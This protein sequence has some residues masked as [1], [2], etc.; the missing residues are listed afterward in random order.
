MAISTQ[1]LLEALK[2]LSPDQLSGIL[3]Q[4]SNRS[5]IR[6]R[7]LHDLRLLPT[8]KDPRPMWVQATDGREFGPEKHSPFPALLW[9][10][11]TGEEITVQSEA[12]KQARGAMWT[13]TPPNTKPLDPEA[14]AR[15]MFEALSPEDQQF[16]IEMQRKARMDA[17]SAAM[18]ALTP[19]QQAAALGQPVE[20]PKKKKA[21]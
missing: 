1:D 17:V 18:S 8:A 21:G 14:Q 20:Q 13:S 11:E 5:P 7:Q 2:G 4:A 15:A 12:E 16:V 9:H 6:D 3:S 10:V 19:S